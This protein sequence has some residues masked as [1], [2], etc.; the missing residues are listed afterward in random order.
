MPVTERKKGSRR[1]DL[2]DLTEAAQQEVLTEE[3]GP[4]GGVY[5]EEPEGVPLST[6]YRIRFSGSYK[7]PD[8]ADLARARQA[9]RQRG[10]S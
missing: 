4:D 6:E 1:R 3:E 10:E 8:H 2:V 9:E 5:P 7:G